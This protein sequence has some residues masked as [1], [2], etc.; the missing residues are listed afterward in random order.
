MG[1]QVAEEIFYG[2]EGISAGCSS[3]LENA[4]STA[5]Q[6][7]KNFGMFGETVG[8]QFIQNKSYSYIDDNLSNQFKEKIDKEIEKVLQESRQRVYKLLYSN[9]FELKNL[10]QQC[11]IHDTLEFDDIEYAVNGEFHK[12][13][14]N[15]VRKPFDFVGKINNLTNV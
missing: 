13:K 15:K 2:D 1:G 10:A 5:R 9:S 8:Y 14:A 7:I 12:I 11:Y 6:M 4:T 3:D